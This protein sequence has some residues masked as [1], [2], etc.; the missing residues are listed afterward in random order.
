[1]FVEDS[2]ALDSGSEAVIGSNQGQRGCGGEKLG[3]G[4][5]RE[6]LVRV[7]RVQNLAGG[8]G[9]DFNAPK[10]VTEIWLGKDSGDALRQ[11]LKFGGLCLQSEEEAQQERELHAFTS[12]ENTLIVA[13]RN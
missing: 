2:G 8:K 9:N 5:R 13:P 7:L 3:I 6:E 4:S 11:R 10:A 12:Q 1:V